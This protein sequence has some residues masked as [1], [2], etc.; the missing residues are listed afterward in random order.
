MDIVIASK[1]KGK[2]KEIKAFFKDVLDINW[3]TFEDFSSFPDIKESGSSF[4]E[5]AK[6][7]A[8]AVSEYTCIHT[9]A[10]DSGLIVDTLGGRPGV[11][12]SRYAGTGATDKDNRVKLLNELNG[13][14]DEKKRT[15]RFVCS[16]IL[17][18]PKKGSVFKSSGICEGHIGVVEKGAYGFG[19]DSIFIPAG[20]KR[21]MAQLSQSEKNKISHRG[22][23][24]IGIKKFL[25]A[26]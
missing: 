5:N 8:K 19:Y 15:A 24:L 11:R 23:A 9:L 1:N 16:M 4:L 3:L 20:F 21:T 7:K 17:W 22:K 6:L 25:L 10:D 14:C 18:D 2:V 13:I 26:K 12:S